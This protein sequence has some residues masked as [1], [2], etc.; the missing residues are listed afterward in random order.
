MNHSLASDDGE[1]QRKDIYRRPSTWTKGA[2]VLPDSTQKRF[3]CR[4]VEEL[5]PDP[6]SGYKNQAHTSSGRS[7]GQPLLPRRRSKNSSSRGLGKIRGHEGTP[8]QF[9]PTSRKG[10]VA[11]RTREFW[12]VPAG[13]GAMRRG[14]TLPYLIQQRSLAFP[15]SRATFRWF[16][17][18]LEAKGSQPRRM[19][20]GSWGGSVTPSPPAWSLPSTPGA[21]CVASHL[22]CCLFVRTQRR[23]NGAI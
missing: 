7:Y 23:K 2:G 14:R 19:N 6:G 5:G 20:Y 11:G 16:G 18:T 12:R 3:V 17:R 10:A 1:V 9:R 13:Q 8:R 4:S 22:V 15:L 21:S